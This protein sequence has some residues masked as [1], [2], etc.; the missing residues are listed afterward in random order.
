MVYDLTENRNKGEICG[1]TF[2]TLFKAPIYTSALSDTNGNYSIKGINY[3]NGT[4]FS[5]IPTKETIIGRALDLDGVDDKLSAPAVGDTSFSSGTVEAW[6]YLKSNN[7]EP[8]IVLRDDGSVVKGRFPVYGGKLRFVSRDGK[9][10]E[11]AAALTMQEWHHV[12]VKFDENGAQFYVDG[13][14]GTYVSGDFSIDGS[15]D[16]GTKTVI[17]TQWG[18]YFHGR[19]DELRVWNVVR[20]QQQIQANMNAPINEQMPEL[21]AY[22][23]LNE[24][25]GNTATDESYNTYTAIIANAD[26]TVWTDEI[27]IDEKFVHTFSPE[28][29][30]VALAPTSTLVNGVDFTDNS[31]LAFTGFV[32][33]EGTDCFADSVEILVDGQSTS[34]QTYTGKDGKF[35][36]EFEPGSTHKISPKYKQH[37]FLPGFLE[38]KNIKQ[39]IFYTHPFLDVEKRT[40]QGYVAGGTCKLPIGISEV[41]IVSA[42]GCI[43]M[44]VQTN[45]QSGLYEVSN[46]PPLNYTVFVHHPNPAIT[47]FGE[48]VSVIDSN[49]GHDFIYRAPLEVRM[50]N[51]PMNTCGMKAIDEG[52]K[53]LVQYIV[54]ETYVNG[55]ES[56]EC[57]L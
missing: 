2:S 54:F 9:I 55:N 33:Y 45:A 35:T 3:G 23:K 50:E 38:V 39:P 22:W 31:T 51:I 30:N 52:K 27:P 32:K 57:P 37:N 11:N 26:S 56:A 20:T 18:N 10:A 34:P 25:G 4:T 47:F 53:K 6:I 49:N 5:A 8:I 7:F 16:L 12:E 19:M 44:S 29:R 42:N 28:S 43:D 14:T 13:E 41:E 15:K 46:L 36:V 17:A 40:I 24:G 21:I 1:G 48:Q